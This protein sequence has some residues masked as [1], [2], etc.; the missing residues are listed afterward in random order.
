MKIITY[1]LA[2]TFPC[3]VVALDNVR[4]DPYSYFN[5]IDKQP[6]LDWLN[7]KSFHRQVW[8]PS[9][10]N[11]TLGVALHW[12]IEDQYIRFGIAAKASGWVGFGISEAGA[13]RG[14]DIILYSVE[15]DELVDSYVLDDLVTPLPDDCQS[16]TLMSS[17]TDDTFILLEVRR[18]LDTGD[19]Q[20][21]PIIDDSNELVLP[22]RVIAAWGDSSIP[23]YHGLYNTAKGAIRFM[24]T[25]SADA[26]QVQR[27]KTKDESNYF[28][29][30]AE[31]YVIPSTETTYAHFCFSNAELAVKG[32]PMDHKLHITKIEAVID[33]NS[34][35]Y[36]HHF[37]LTG[38]ED[39]WNSSGDCSSYPGFEVAYAWAPGDMPMILPHNVGSPLGLRG[40][41][42]FRLEIHYNNPNMD[43]NQIDSSG[44]RIHYTNE[45]REYD[46]GVFQTGDPYLSLMNIPVS[47]NGTLAKH[48]FTCNS[49]C[50]SLFLNTS[51]TVISEHLHMHKSGLSIVNHQR[52]N[53]EIIRSGE[54]QFWDF[55]QQGNLGIVQQP[56]VIEPGDSFQTICNY[57]AKEGQVFGLGSS[58]EMCIAFLFY[59][60]RQ[61]ISI[62]SGEMPFTCS[63]G[64]GEAIPDCEVE[65]TASELSGIDQVGRRFGIAPTSCSEEDIPNIKPTFTPS[66]M[67]FSSASIPIIHYLII[68]VLAV[69]MSMSK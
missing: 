12:T 19:S 30:K 44:I 45:T 63:I 59:Y 16:W 69:S 46:L 55:E 22:T 27:L 49:G 20:D 35:Q 24:D 56:F 10:R 7:G 21:R 2:L 9:P 17:I 54:V 38:M 32:V 43:A 50:S 34:S 66:E 4:L 18:L 47:V 65:W 57:K 41:Q 5:G 62:S 51:I 33:S 14:S 36:V 48:S 6:Y 64:I 37:I 31:R 29:L 13:M 42:S 26:S 52:R 60:P 68:C 3:V 11:S 40:F 15:T 67:P 39:K 1:I 61:T 25:F 23:S 53:D 8:L 28:E 58:Q